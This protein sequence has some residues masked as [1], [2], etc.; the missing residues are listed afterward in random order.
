MK[1]KELISK[2]QKLDPEAEVVVT[3]NNFELQHEVVSLQGV[4]EYKTARKVKKQFRDAFD[5]YAYLTE[6]YDLFNG[7]ETV[8]LL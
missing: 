8:I 3:S 4:T 5:G 1:N 6:V 2:L 7:E